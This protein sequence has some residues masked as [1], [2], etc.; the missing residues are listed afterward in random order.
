MLTLCINVNVQACSIELDWNLPTRPTGSTQ[1]EYT[2]GHVITDN[3]DVIPATKVR[4]SISKGPKYRFPFKI[5]SLNV[6]ERSCFFK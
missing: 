4:N 1:F 2:A 6:V 3:L 5:D